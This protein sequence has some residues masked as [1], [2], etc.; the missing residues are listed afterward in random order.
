M[1]ALLLP[2]LL[3]VAACE[4]DPLAVAAATVDVNAEV[5]AA[6][7]RTLAFEVENRG[8]RTVYLGACD[9]KVVAFAQRRGE[10]D[11]DVSVFCLAVSSSSPV[12]L[13]PGRSVRGTAQVPG[14]GEYRVGVVIRT[15]DGAESR[16]V[17]SGDVV[18]PG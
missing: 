3:L 5:D 2:L 1:R 18:V 16:L 12:E 9:Q 10:Y 6:T 14:P 7:P 17:A 8:G 13:Q 11:D 15:E 4:S